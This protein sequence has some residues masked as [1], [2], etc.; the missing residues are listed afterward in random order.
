M[1][2][3]MPRRRKP[4]ALRRRAL[5]IDQSVG[6]PLYLFALTGQEIL[7]I[8]DIS[9]ISRDD[10]DHLLGYQR[11]EVRQHV[12]DIVDYLDSDDILF[13]NAIILALSSRVG[14]T[15]SRGPQIHDDGVS[16]GILEIPLS[17][18]GQGKPAWIVD[19]QQRTLALSKSARRALPVP[20][21]GFVADEVDLQRDQFIRVNNQRPLPR[22][23]L[24]E[25]LPEIVAPL[26][27]RLAVRKIPAAL[28]EWLNTDA[29]SPFKGLIKRAS[30][31]KQS[32]K[33]A[34]VSDTA[35]V[36]MI[37]ESLT[38]PSGALFPYRNVTTGETDFTGIGSVLATYWQAV[39][40]TFP[41]AWGKPPTK[42]RLMHGAGIRAMGRVMD[43]I[44]GWHRPAE[45]DPTAHAMRELGRIAPIC[46]WTGGY[47]DELDLSWNEIQNVPRHIR[48]LTDVLVR[49]YVQGRA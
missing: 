31:S 14:F 40:E 26:P 35:V 24:T 7:S 44:M 21:S 39:K 22:G 19:G 17:A 32:K 30:M 4:K 42:S 5:R 15:R 29:R 46:R 20:V 45:G 48:M 23:L 9:R 8:A 10:A 36:Q 43:R 18:N 12:Q 49:S 1:R 13:P 38:S 27:A 6:H 3:A 47:W 34:V 28:C 11:P 33:T 16:A 25:L 37:Q 41:D 2:M